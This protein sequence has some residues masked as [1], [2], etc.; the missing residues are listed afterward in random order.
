MSLVE[1]IANAQS[2]GAAIRPRVGGFPYL[3]ES[4]RLAGVT[5]I[6]VTVPSWTT[7]L[8]TAEGSVVQQGTPMTEASAAVPPFD[9]DAFRT[10]LRADQ[11][12]HIT[13]PDWME[14][15]W[16]AGVTW[17]EVDLDGRT[18]TYRSPA[19]DS[20]VEHYPAVELESADSPPPDGPSAHDSSADDGASWIRP[21]R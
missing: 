6:A 19:G 13:F 15:T 14:A 12:G 8:T 2:R 3:A 11:D 1:T 20:Y 9:L 7:V 16:R 17:Y 21:P 4:L 5:R 18:C 10:A